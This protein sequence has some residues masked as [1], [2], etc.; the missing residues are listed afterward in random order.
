MERFFK[1][2]WL[3]SVAII[4][5]SSFFAVSSYFYRTET[6]LKVLRVEKIKN[7]FTFN[8]DVKTSMFLNMGAE[9]ILKIDISF[10]CHSRKQHAAL[11]GSLS[12]IVNDFLIETGQEELDAWVKHG[13]IVAIKRRLIK[14]ANKYTDQKVTLVFFE[15]LNW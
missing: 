1:K 8:E 9:N 11:T 15:A 3:I 5:V 6:G 12:A 13:N 7:Y 10:P 14:I 2:E 4:V